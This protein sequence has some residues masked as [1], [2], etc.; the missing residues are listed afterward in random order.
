MALWKVG[1]QPSEID[2]AFVA[3]VK[4]LREHLVGLA[5]RLGVPTVHSVSL[6]H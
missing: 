3:L 2:V 4:E 6:P 5:T 1:G